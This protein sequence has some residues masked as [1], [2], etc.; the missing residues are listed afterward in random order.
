MARRFARISTLGQCAVI[1]DGVAYDPPR[2]ARLVQQIATGRVFLVALADQE[3]HLMSVTEL[4][5]NALLDHLAEY[6]WQAPFWL[7]DDDAPDVVVTE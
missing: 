3:T 2:R 6:T 1:L 4:P 5:T 7:S